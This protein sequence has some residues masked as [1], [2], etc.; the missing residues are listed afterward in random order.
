MTAQED[1][2][3][4][5]RGPGLDRRSSP[6]QRGGS[7]PRWRP[8]WR[9][10]GERP[11]TESDRWADSWRRPGGGRFWLVLAGLLA[12]NWVLSGL[13]LAPPQRLEVPYTFFREQVVEGNVAEVRTIGDTIEG[14]F[15]EAVTFPPEA[16]GRGGEGQEP[17]PPEPGQVLG[18]QPR[19]GTLFATQRPSFADDGLM[20]LLLREDVTV[21]AEP[22]DRVPVWQQML[23]GF[24]PTILLVALLV[25]L[26]RRS[27]G[28]AG[29]GG[30]G[31][32]RSKARRYSPE[33]GPRTTFEDVAG[34]D[35]VEEEVREIVDFLRDPDR[36]RRLGAC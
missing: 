26:A 5:R 24:G 35:D 8:P 10:E 15:E 20:G 31:L 2:A 27:A 1:G 19:S 30:V 34:I 25:W 6:R 4:A 11:D 36:Y 21:N 33:V 16:Q 13:L 32:G 18:G 9:V 12:L 14:R 28:A 17:Q 29:L 22:P 23:F 3:V 7:S